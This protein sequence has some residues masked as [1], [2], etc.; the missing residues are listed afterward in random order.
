MPLSPD[1]KYTKIKDR[2]DEELQIGIADAIAKF[3]REEFYLMLAGID[4]YFEQRRRKE[5]A[6]SAA[7]NN[8]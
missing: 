2:T 6:A 5:E 1:R 3:G 4:S 8:R 7:E